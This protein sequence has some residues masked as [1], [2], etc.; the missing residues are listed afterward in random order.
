M[1]EYN[2]RRM[3]KWR[4]ENGVSRA[5]GYCNDLLSW[6]SLVTR[7]ILLFL[8]VFSVGSADAATTGGAG[9]PWET[10]LTVLS[11]S[12]TGPVAYSVSLIGIVGA[13]GI[14][15]FAGGQVNEFMRAVLFC[16]LVI[17]FIIA[18][19]NTLTAFG[20][21]TGAEVYAPCHH[22]PGWC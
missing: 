14:L 10:P 22:S 12:I 6:E 15:I 2:T 1:R 13:G 19:K 3:R 18:A 17:A 16:V 4:A 11:N 21:A 7:V 9:L 5:R 20:F 8:I